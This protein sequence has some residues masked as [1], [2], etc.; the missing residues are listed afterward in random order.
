MKN[1]V[2]IKNTWKK[3]LKSDKTDKESKDILV[4]HYFSNLVKKIANNLTRK[5][6]YKIST[7]ELAS[8]GVFGL[9]RALESFDENR[10]VKFE[11]YAYS[12]IWGSVIDGMREEDRIPRSVRIRQSK[13]AKAKIELEA[14]CNRQVSD[15]EAVLRA[16]IDLK[17]YNKN[18]NRFHANYFY[19]IETSADPNFSGNDGTNKKDF[20]E[21]LANTNEASVDSSMIRQEFLYK[22]IGKNL[23]PAERKIIYYYYYEN[24][25]LCDIARKLGL[26]ES[27]ISQKHQSILKKLKKRI[28]VNPKY[29]D[30]NIANVINKCNDKNSLEN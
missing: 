9:Y 28:E 16:G 30:E 1:D 3:Y 8:H 19:S 20:N 2:N 22:L 23:T 29:F 11:T 26:S 12:R 4:E 21:Y 7:D 27:R 13:I 14:E 24:M 17:E 5:F 15:E 6:R 25:P 18:K 10:G